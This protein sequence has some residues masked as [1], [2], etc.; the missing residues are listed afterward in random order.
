[1]SIFKEESETKRVIF[2]I[3]IDIALRLERAKKDAR[4]FGKKLDVDTPVSK[5]VEKFLRKA[6]KKLEEMEISAKK[7]GRK[8]VSR[9]LLEDFSQAG[10][11]ETDLDDLDEQPPETDNDDEYPTMMNNNDQQQGEG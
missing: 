4:K 9:P 6:E 11:S 2:N 1:M 7:S 3:D 5:A 10:E 8:K